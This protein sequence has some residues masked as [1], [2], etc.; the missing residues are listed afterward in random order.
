MLR[1]FLVYVFFISIWS[2][3][4]KVESESS[5]EIIDVQKK[6]NIVPGIFS[7]TSYIPLEFCED[8][9][10][11]DITKVE[12]NNS[13][14]IISDKSKTKSILKFD[15]VGNCQFKIGE[16]GEGPGK[17]ILPFDF[18]I[19]PDQDILCVLDNNQSK[20]LYYSLV[21]GHFIEEERIDFKAK[22]IK[23]LDSENLAVHLDGN[24][25]GNE[26]DYHG[27]IF[28]LPTGQKKSF[29]YDFSKTDQM[30][31]AGDFYNLNKEVLFS[32]SMNDTI[33]TVTADGFKPKYFIDFSDK[34]I[35]KETKVKPFNEMFD[36]MM[37]E[38]PH[39]HNG[40]F[41]ENSKYL[42][43]I[44]W[45]EGEL[46][47]SMIYDKSKKTL[48]N[49]SDDKVIFKRPFYLNENEVYCYLTNADYA[50]YGLEPNFGKSENPVIVKFTLK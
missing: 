32:K 2:C 49:S 1:S 35:P 38:L 34:G 22:S 47:N 13:S 4:K 45:D 11:G 40:N 14:F 46:E 6:I 19:I 17:F 20:L 30:V 31:T 15:S 16:A 25:F 26:M 21:D 42:F 33:Y 5:I 27:L 18:S 28:H 36:Q 12:F 44:S 43:F 9:I 7:D 50:S 23:F 29:V 8:C 48:Y 39:Y 24:F 41:I 10:V 37:K 3:Q